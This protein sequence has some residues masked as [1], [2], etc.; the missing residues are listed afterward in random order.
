L[1]QVR[2]L[3]DVA[4]AHRCEDK[5]REGLARTLIASVGPVVSDE[6]KSHG[7]RTDISPANDAY[8]MKPLIS[9]M[10]AA[11]GKTAPRSGVIASQRDGA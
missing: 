6:L 2:R 8:F 11:L 5:L 7:L 1:G 3:V 9:A 10:A 4:Q